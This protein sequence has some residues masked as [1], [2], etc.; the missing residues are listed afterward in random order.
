MLTTLC[1]LQV[2]KQAERRQGRIA[3]AMTL[4]EDFSRRAHG[5]LEWVT[6]CEEQLKF[7]PERSED[8]STLQAR[9]DE[10]KV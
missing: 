9:L 7:N 6:D 1:L 8:E 10:H 5:F 3:D 2:T 4:A